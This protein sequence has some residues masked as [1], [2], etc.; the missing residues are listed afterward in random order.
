MRREDPQAGRVVRGHPIVLGD[1][2]GC[3]AEHRERTCDRCETGGRDQEAGG[4]DA[5]ACL[6]A[7]GG[8]E[9][10]AEMHL[11]TVNGRSARIA[12]LHEAFTAS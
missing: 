8:L 12:L 4:R 5:Q 1:V 6:Q 11:A 7:T 10:T 9:V 2:F 3:R